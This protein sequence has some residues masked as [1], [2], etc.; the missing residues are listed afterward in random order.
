MHD[1]I[2]HFNLFRVY[3]LVALIVFRD[4]GGAQHKT[5]NRQD[6]V[7]KAKG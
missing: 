5:F 2:D 4:G 3:N 6:T 1:K 7:N